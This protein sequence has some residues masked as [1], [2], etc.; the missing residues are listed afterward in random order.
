MF[1]PG[2]VDLSIVG[3]KII[4]TANERFLDPLFFGHCSAA[5]GS[6]TT[7]FYRDPFLYHMPTFMTSYM[8]NGRLFFC[9]FPVGE[10][11]VSRDTFHF[12][13]NIAHNIYDRDFDLTQQGRA[14]LPL[15]T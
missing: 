15:Q 13:S 8:T 9:S 14:I 12:F 1:V 4:D 3:F 10:T 5:I 7:E 2:P 6:P 11:G